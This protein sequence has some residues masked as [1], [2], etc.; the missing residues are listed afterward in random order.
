MM[1]YSAEA[2][3]MIKKGELLNLERCIEIAL[4]MQPDIV[5]AKNTVTATETK[6]GQAKANYYPQ[7]NWIAGY[8]RYAPVP[9][10][11]N[12]FSGTVSRHS[13]DLYSTYIALNQTIFDF[14]KTPT[15]VKIQNLNFDSSRSDLENITEQLVFLVKQAYY[16][17]VQARYNKIVAEDTLKQAEQH[18]EQAKGFFEAGIRPEFDVT[19]AEVD[20]S[21]AKLYLIS[22]ENAVQI[23]IENLNNTIGISE[24]PKYV[25]DENISLLKYEITFEDA[26]KRAYK[27]RPDL[28]SLI[29]KKTASEESIELAKKDYYPQLT[30][31]ASYEWAG[32]TFPLEQGWNVTA[33]LSFSVFSGFLTKYQVKESKANFNVLKAVED[34]LRQKIFLEVKEAYLTLRAAEDAI[35]TAK[36]GVEHAKKNLDIA[37]RRYAAGVGNPIE[38]TDAEESWANARTSYIQALY[39]DKVAQGRLEKAMGV[40]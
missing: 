19:K 35:P 23:S 2:D 24:A 31:S 33:V 7:I 27:N 1:T 39:D 28:Q 29:A 16:G 21:R 22:A 13:F 32:E 37:N 25:L 10:T 36:L 15:Q 6:I 40:R 18:L 14:G 8:T 3:E 26:L 17:V 5:A 20:L 11:S 9:S 30:G 4:K 12:R 38:V 34:S